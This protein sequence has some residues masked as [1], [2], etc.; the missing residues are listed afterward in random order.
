MLSPLG[1]LVSILL[2]AIANTSQYSIISNY[3][4]YLKQWLKIV[5]KHMIVDA[6][7]HAVSDELCN[8]VPCQFQYYIFEN[9]TLSSNP[10]TNRTLL[11]VSGFYGG[12]YLGPNI[13]LNSFGI[14][15]AAKIIYFPIANPSGWIHNSRN[16]FNSNID[17]AHDF[18]FDGN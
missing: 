8:Q 1:I 4:D 7:S 17:I 9:E 10:N 2:A 15:N 3:E 14:L 18:P 5:P 6:S 13:L 12:Q 16:I 11:L